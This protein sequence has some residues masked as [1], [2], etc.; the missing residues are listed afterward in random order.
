VCW[1]AGHKDAGLETIL[2]AKH[3]VVSSICENHQKKAVQT[4]LQ[5]EKTEKGGDR[6]EKRRR[7]EKLHY[8]FCHAEGV[9]MIFILHT[10]MQKKSS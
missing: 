6:R 7:N 1:Q 8:R 3:K 5:K 2:C 10:G 4:W 9:L